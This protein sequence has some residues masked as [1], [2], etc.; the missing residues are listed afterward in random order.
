MKILLFLLCALFFAKPAIA[1]D[2]IFARYCEGT[3]VPRELAKA[4]ARQES[5]MNPLSINIEGQDYT[6]KN[7]EE[8]AALIQKAEAKKLSYDVGLMQINSQWTRQWKMD[9][10]KLLDPETNVRL[11]VKLLHNE[12]DKHGLNWRAVGKYHSPD[13]LRGMHYAGMVSRRVRGDSRLKSAIT[14]PVMPDDAILKSALAN[15]RLRGKL[16][17]GGYAGYAR[18]PMLHHADFDQNRLQRSPIGWSN[19]A[20]KRQQW[21]DQAR[22]QTIR[23]KAMARKRMRGRHRF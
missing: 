22:A 8:A 21:L 2:K 12:I 3:K 14:N 23:A 16:R 11:G 15:P 7:R 17:K 13:P 9:P 1:F 5:G 19:I 20:I 6:P 18:L 4:V 10:L